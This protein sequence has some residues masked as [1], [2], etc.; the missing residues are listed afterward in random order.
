MSFK[1]LKSFTGAIKALCDR[2]KPREL[3]ID[4]ICINQKKMDEKNKQ[5]PMMSNIYGQA[6]QVCVWLSEGDDDS[7][8]AFEFIDKQ[9]LKLQK[10][11]ALCDDQIASRKWNVMLN[12]MK[13]PWFS[14]RWVVLDI[15]LVN[16]AKIYCGKDTI[17]WK[18]F[19]DAMQLFVEVETAT[20][21]LS[22]LMK[23]IR[24]VPGWFEYVLALGANLL[25]DAT[26]TLFRNSKDE[27]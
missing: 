20:H 24:N 23:K 6:K 1:I 2:K 4:A 5:V 21:R 10:F 7:K 16:T 13:W 25:L 9:V 8:I 19:A 3:W 17:P 12:F 18:D 26:G 27:G 14:C 15:A 11:N 22:Q